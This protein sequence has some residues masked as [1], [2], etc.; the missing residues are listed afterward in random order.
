MRVQAQ[1]AR[2]AHITFARVT[3]AGDYACALHTHSRFDPHAL[4]LRTHTLCGCHVDKVTRFCYS[5]G[6]VFNTG[7]VLS[8]LYVSVSGRDTYYALSRAICLWLSLTALP[9]RRR[10]LTGRFS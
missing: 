10:S 1:A 6:V 4:L 9:P 7:R 8:P 5:G 3:V 2:E